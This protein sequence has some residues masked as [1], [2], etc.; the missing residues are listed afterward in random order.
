MELF[1]LFQKLGI[2]LGLG[3]LVGL[4]RERVAE[5]LAGFRT[6]PLVTVLGTVTGL[7]ALELGGWVV[8]AGLLA[9]ALLVAAGNLL[10]S[11]SGE[12]DPGLTTEVAL[13]L[14]Y[15]VGAY[16]VTGRT[17]VAVVVG[18]GTAV[19]LHLKGE[20]HGLAGRLGERDARAVFRFALLSLVILPVL[21]DRTFGPYAV[22]NPRQ[23]WWM[24]VLIVGIGL[25]G[26]VAYKLVGGRAGTVLGGVL[27]GLISS[28]ATT[29][30][31]ARR[32]ARSAP[33]VPAAALV[34]VIASTVVFVRV[35]VEVAVVAPGSFT[36]MAPPLVGM[37]VAMVV[38]AAVLWLV[39]R[40]GELS[41]PEQTNP[42]ELRP[43]LVF[44]LLYAGI[45][46]AVAAVKEHLGSGALY[47]VATVSGL[48]DVDAIT[49]S[50]GRLVETGRLAAPTGARLI[51]VAALAN[52]VF[53]GALAGL[54]GGRRLLL[55]VGWVF[56]PAVGIGALV[57]WL[58]G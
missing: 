9:L 16:L 20:L 22:L 23:I 2:A 55:R 54:A 3:L 56:V 39:G 58:W 1:P 17:E 11:R 48:T 45:L 36:A 25:G 43:A 44:A 7:L 49:L 13:L 46:L 18:G 42:T 19:L 12:V 21:P 28:T 4:Q 57:L 41:M 33:A 8:V 27:G 31:F 52:L 47:A 34:I 53:K 35:L 14:M 15:A 40:P 32:A 30:S 26:Y 37:L 29:L 51:L 24:V 38:L 10:Q 5:R 6:V 50:T